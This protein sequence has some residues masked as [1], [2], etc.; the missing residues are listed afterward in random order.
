M[1]GTALLAMPW[2]VMLASLTPRLSPLRG[3]TYVTY[4]RRFTEKIDGKE[5]PRS[6]NP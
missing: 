6:P 5:E 2:I 4:A 3:Y 1:P